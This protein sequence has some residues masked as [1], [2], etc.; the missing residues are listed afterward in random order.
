[1]W[2]IDDGGKMKTTSE[3]KKKRRLNRLRTKSRPNILSK[4]SHNLRMR[5]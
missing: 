2:V 4:S 1:M 5:L 3:E